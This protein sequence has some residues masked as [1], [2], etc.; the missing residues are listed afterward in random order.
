MKNDLAEF[1]NVMSTDANNLFNQASSQVMEKS[2]S[3][4][5]FNSSSSPPPD[6]EKSSIN[7]NSNNKQ[8]QMKSTTSNIQVR[9][10]EE[11]KQIQT[12]EDVYLNQLIE[13][14][15]DYIQWL[16][17][18]NLENFKSVISDLLIENSSM[19]LLY[20]QLVPA[21]ISN[22]QFWSRYFYRINQLDEEHKKRLK[23]LERVVNKDSNNDDQ[24]QTTA[25]DWDDQEEEEEE[26][27]KEEE[28]EIEKP[29]N[30]VKSSTISNEQEIKSSS[31]SSDNNIIIPRKDSSQEIDDDVKSQSQL[32]DEWDKVS[33]NENN[34]LE[35]LKLEQTDDLV[36]KNKKQEVS[37]KEEDKE[38]DDWGDAA[39]A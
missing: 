24:Q 13:S 39:D 37:N 29:L 35:K 34:N 36:N 6:T 8:N 30:N 21:Q 17:S 22:E 11:L 1:T 26:E 25:T 14:N 32:G 3:I 27:K 9:Y 28:E 12:N 19:R 4:L 16:A 18:F 15:E 2:S 5:L 38:W 20:S 7:N 33:D 10:N 31:S 23:L